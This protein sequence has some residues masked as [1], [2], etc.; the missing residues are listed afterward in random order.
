MWSDSGQWW[1]GTTAWRDARAAVLIRDRHRCQIGLEGICRIT[2]TQVD[3]IRNVA[4]TG[5][6]DDLE[7]LC[8]T[9]NLQA[10]CEWCH[11]EKTRAEQAGKPFQPKDYQREGYTVTRLLDLVERPTPQPRPAAA[12]PRRKRKRGKPTFDPSTY[13]PRPAIGYTPGANDDQ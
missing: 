3:H 5:D 10:V 8:E 12:M 13:K 7:T 2:A 6:D 9:T 4:S 1:T 11:R